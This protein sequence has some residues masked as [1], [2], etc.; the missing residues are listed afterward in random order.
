M[1]GQMCMWS[2]TCI[3]TGEALLTRI[4]TGVPGFAQQLACFTP[5]AGT[6]YPG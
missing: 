2:S 3:R 1:Q 6:R 4:P 5:R